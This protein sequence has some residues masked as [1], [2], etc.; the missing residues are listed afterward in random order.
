MASNRA[1]EWDFGAARERRPG[2]PV[3][4]LVAEALGHAVQRVTRG[5]R[6]DCE[7]AVSISSCERPLLLGPPVPLLSGLRDAAG[8]LAAN[9]TPPN[10][11]AAGATAGVGCPKAGAALLRSVGQILACE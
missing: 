5:V 7:P 6:D 4:L 10:A 8:V 9:P 11:G 2:L 1:I 3:R